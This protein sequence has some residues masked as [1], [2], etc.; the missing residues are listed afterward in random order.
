MEV[1]GQLHAPAALTLGKWSM[2]RI[3]LEAGWVQH[4]NEM[5]L[6]CC[7]VVTSDVNT[8]YTRCSLNT[9]PWL[10]KEWTMVL[11]PPKELTFM[12]RS[13]FLFGCFGGDLWK[14]RVP[15]VT[16]QNVS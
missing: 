4:S 8:D 2:V 12:V 9:L 15:C 7:Y 10:C 14:N 13:T 1:S 5:L 16:R 3:E 6:R 11:W